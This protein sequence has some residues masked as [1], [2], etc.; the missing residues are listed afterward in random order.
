MIELVSLPLPAHSD[1][2]AVH[3]LTA[4][5]ALVACLALTAVEGAVALLLESGRRALQGAPDPALDTILDSR[6][7]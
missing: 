5:P 7:A 3:I 1:R 6:A 2:E 4:T